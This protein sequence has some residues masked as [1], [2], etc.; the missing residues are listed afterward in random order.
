MQN[1]KENKCERYYEQEYP[2]KGDYVIVKINEVNEDVGAYVSLLE[3][4]LEGMIPI[5]ECTTR[6]FKSLSS[7]VRVGRTEVALVTEVDKERG[8]IDLSKSKVSSDDIVK[9]EKKWNRA[10]FVQTV[11]TSLSIKL[12]IPLS[13]INKEI[14]WPLYKKYNSAYEAFLMYVDDPNSVPEINDELGEIVKK[15]LEPSTYKFNAEIDVTCLKSEG[16]EAIKDSLNCALVSYPQ[17]SITLIRSPSFLL[18]I[19]DED[20]DRGLVFLNNACDIVSKRIKEY[21]G[22]MSVKVPP[23][24]V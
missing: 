23:Y 3:Y 22:D 10:K 13:E 2:E 4:N 8:Y 9:C 5:V 14:T 6:R 1:E 16:I 12:S 15:R 21:G 7:I 11:M 20:K 18:S 17:L 24:I 19:S